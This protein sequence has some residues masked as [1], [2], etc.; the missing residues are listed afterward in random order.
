M[1]PA[2]APSISIVRSLARAIRTP[3]TRG[4]QEVHTRCTPVSLWCISGAS[5]VHLW[6]TA[7]GA[8]AQAHTALTRRTDSEAVRNLP[9]TTTGHLLREWG[10]FGGSEGCGGSRNGSRPFLRVRRCDLAGTTVLGWRGGGKGTVWS[11]WGALPMGATPASHR[12]DTVVTPSP[13]RTGIGVTWVGTDYSTENNEEPINP[14]ERIRT[15][16]GPAA[17]YRSRC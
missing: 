1:R 4:A 11:P 9:D 6:Y 16:S 12:H 8:E 5:G 17:V 14:F 2:Q 7:R 13:R 3:C 10:V 15:G